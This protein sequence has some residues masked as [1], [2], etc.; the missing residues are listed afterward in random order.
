[1][2]HPRLILLVLLT[3]YAGCVWSRSLLAHPCDSPE[4]I[5][6]VEVNHLYGA[7]GERRFSQVCYWDRCDTACEHIRGWAA[8]RFFVTR[9]TIDPEERDREAWPVEIRKPL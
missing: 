5:D 9:T 6:A 8:R 4:V 2:K 1:M 7:D 3:L